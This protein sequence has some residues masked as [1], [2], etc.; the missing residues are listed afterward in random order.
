MV[1]RNRGVFPCLEYGDNLGLP[2][3]L[4]DLVSCKAYVEHCMQSF[5]GLLTKM[6]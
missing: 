3:Y 6:L 2:S 5:I 4:G 1:I